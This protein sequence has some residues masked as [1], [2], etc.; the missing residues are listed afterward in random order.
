[1]FATETMVAPLV[2]Y[3]SPQKV[4]L[5]PTNGSVIGFTLVNLESFGGA[6]ISSAAVHTKIIVKVAFF[7]VKQSQPWVERVRRGSTS[8][9]ACLGGWAAI[10]LTTGRAHK[11]VHRCILSYLRLA[12]V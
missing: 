3:N 5:A 9:G 2:G 12:H 10:A 6:K 1:M 11:D 4:M 7:A 8:V